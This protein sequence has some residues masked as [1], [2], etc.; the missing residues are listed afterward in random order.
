MGTSRKIRA[1]HIRRPVSPDLSRVR[2]ILSDGPRWISK[3]LQIYVCAR[4]RDRFSSDI[5][6][7]LG[8]EYKVIAFLDIAPCS[9]LEVCCNHVE[10]DYFDEIT[11]CYIPESFYF[12]ELCHVFTLAFDAR[13]AWEQMLGTRIIYYELKKYTALAV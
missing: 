9:V 7:S 5:S 13:S 1:G 11:L 4:T 3:C 12:E 10:I 6:G 8:G 2:A